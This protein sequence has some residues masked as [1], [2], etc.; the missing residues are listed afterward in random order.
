MKNIFYVVLFL[1]PFVSAQS[2]TV[3][4][5]GQLRE[6]SELDSRNM[7]FG[8]YT[9]AYH[10]LRARLRADATVNDYVHVVAEIQDAR[11]FGDS[12]TTLASGSSAFDLRQGYVEISKL[13]CEHLSMRLGRQVLS[14]GNERVLGA[15]DWNNFGQVF[16]AGLLR[17][18][19]GDVT[20][21]LFGAAIARHDFAVYNGEQQ[22]K[23]DYFMAGAWGAWK[24]AECKSALNV[25]YIY[26]NPYTTSIMGS[27]E[28]FRHT[29]GIDATGSYEN[30]DAEIDGAY[31]FGYVNLDKQYDIG[32]YMFG[33]RAGYTI[34][35]A[36]NMR[37]GAGI[38]V[39]SG[40][41]PDKTD[42]YGA[43]NT[44]FA[45]NHKFYGYMDYFTNIPDNTMTLGLMDIIVQWS[46][47]PRPDCKIG[48][49]GHLFRTM[50]DPQKAMANSTAKQDIGM[51]LDLTVATKIHNAV[52]IQG[53]F[54]IF[55]WNRDRAI[56][57]GR[58]TTNWAYVMTTV[59]F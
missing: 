3:T 21:D 18:H 45:T 6:R 33:V 58:K 46:I 31:Q 37:L 22:Y 11:R 25:F 32:A 43:F 2:Q 15:I 8:S 9:D 57:L 49:D 19:S 10:L 1:L 40:N 27:A 28:Q 39:L 41:D 4:F 24:P 59:N 56:R 48:L 52:N 17:I 55:D 23:R 7:A 47:S 51:E 29:A 26:D 5:S 34:E 35:S 13:G 53:G 38:D 30:F 36:Y 42:K 44:L 12:Q 16:D 54:S 50:I 20:V 14:Y